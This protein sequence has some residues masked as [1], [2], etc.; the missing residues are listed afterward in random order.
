MNKKRI[1]SAIAALSI[2]AGVMAGCGSKEA[3]TTGNDEKMKISVG[4]TKAD[5]SWKND[6]YYKFIADKMN[7]DIDFKTLSADSIG[8]KS[9]IWISSGDMP[10]MTYSDFLLDEYLKYGEQGMVATLPENWEKTYPNLGFSM[11]MTGAYKAMHEAG[12][13]N[14]YGLLV[15][16]DHYS[17]YLDDFRAAYAEGKDL[18]EVMDDNKYKYI[19]TYGFAYRKDWAEQLGI[20]TDLIMDYDDFIDMVHKFKEADLGGVGADNVVGI[21]V[22]YTEAPNIFITAFNSSYK[23]FH[24]DESGKYVCGLLDDATTEGVK[25]YA[26]AYRTGV[27]SPGF[28]TQKTQDLNSLFCSQRSGIIFPRAEVSGLRTLRK[29]F[30]K[31][32]PGKTAEECISVCWLRSPDGTISGR[33]AGNYNRAWYFSPKLSDEKFDRILQLA[34]YVSSPDGGPQVRLGVPDVDYKK[35]ENGEY[36]ILREKD[37]NGT[38]PNLNTKYPSYD[39]FRY[40]LNPQFTVTTIPDPYME[41][42]MRSLSAEKLANE[43]KLLDWDLQRDFYAADDYAKFNAAYD[44]NNLFAELVVSEGNIEESWNKKKAEFEAEAKKVADN[45]NKAIFGE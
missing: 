17:R 26:E 28:Y 29:D 44:V 3:N 8:E 25:A 22:D 34:D 15:P 41:N 20:K 38:Y 43:T 40:F 6:D 1:I 42:L 45:M 2:F 39:F 5:E 4:F 12:N 14:F 21:A 32:N 31:S 24:L 9:R 11:A 33:E 13:G 27:L 7:I 37:E 10:D 19:D 18:K 36:T 16:M 23:Y 35:E 30:E